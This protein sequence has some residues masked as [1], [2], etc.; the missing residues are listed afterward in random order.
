M[1]FDLI[2]SEG[3]AKEGYPVRGLFSLQFK[4]LDPWNGIALFGDEKGASSHAVNLQSDSTQYLKYEGSVDPTITGGFS[5]TFNYKNFTASFLITAQ[6]GNKIRLTPAYRSSYSDLDATPGDEE[7]TTIPSIADLYAN[8]DLGGAGAYPYNNYNY[9][10]ARVVDGSF[11]RLKTASV[12]YRLS[13]RLLNNIGLNSVSLSLIG[14]NLWLIYA[15][16][17]L[18]GQD[19]EFFNSGGVALPINKQF[20]LSLKVGF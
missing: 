6:A 12:S 5:N 10:S 11:V 3:G 19:P 7:L 4:G 9:S 16:K 14:N 20:V 15:D 2:R 8:F 1:I 18:N 17:K 13:D